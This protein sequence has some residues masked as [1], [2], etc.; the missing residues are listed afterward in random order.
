MNNPSGVDMS[1]VPQMTNLRHLKIFLSTDTI[2]LRVLEH[3]PRLYLLRDLQIMLVCARP[4]CHS[5][6]DYRVE[7]GGCKML[8]KR[9]FHV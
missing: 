9:S 8:L 1:S 5:I 6:M 3:L 2:S 7:V 4:S